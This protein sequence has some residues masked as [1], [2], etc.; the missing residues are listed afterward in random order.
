M[1]RNK[2]VK[3]APEEAEPA[4]EAVQATARLGHETCP[5]CHGGRVY[6]DK[7]KYTIRGAGR[8]FTEYTYR[9]CL[10]CWHKW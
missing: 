6:W 10:D 3:S 4:P 2:S 7:R 5:K 9:S 1:A 8:P